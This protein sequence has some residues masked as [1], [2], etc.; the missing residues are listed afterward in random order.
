MRRKL[1]IVG[2]GVPLVAFVVALVYLYL[3]GTSEPTFEAATQ[4]LAREHTVVQLREEPPA[5]LI[6]PSE[7][8]AAVTLVIILPDDER[9]VW[10]ATRALGL[11]DYVERD[12]LGLIPAS[13]VVG[14]DQLWDLVELVGA[15]VAVEG[16]YLAA[17][18]GEPVSAICAGDG[19]G[20][21]W[22]GVAVV[23]SDPGARLDRCGGHEVFWIDDAAEP[24]G[25][26][27][28]WMLERE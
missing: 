17:F 5:A 13:A 25:S 18:A 15:Y 22:S 1:A 8:P 4:E 16:V 23:R 20:G 3:F 24:A 11:L 21:E 10:S 27:V 26:M 14:P 12:G 28:R 9:H 2:L 6:V 19:P 7:P